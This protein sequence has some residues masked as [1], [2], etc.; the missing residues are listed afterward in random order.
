[1]QLA[2]KIV[3]ETATGEVTAETELVLAS[4][5]VTVREIIERRVRDEVARFNGRKAET[6]FRGLVQPTETEAELNGYR[7]REPRR[8]DV[9]TQCAKALKAFRSNGFFMLVNDRQVEELDEE[10]IVQPD[11]RIAFVKLLPLVGG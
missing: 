2:L 9:E 8:L 1:M 10:I 5:C 6:L 7:L 4:Q 11:T 3:D